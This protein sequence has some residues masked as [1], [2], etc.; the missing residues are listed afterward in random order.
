MEV[1]STIITSNMTTEDLQSTEVSE[2]PLNCMERLL[3]AT[4]L[5]SSKG[6]IQDVIETNEF[7]KTLVLTEEEK[8]AV[9]FAV[10]T[11]KV[12][13]VDMH[14]PT[15]SKSKDFTKNFGISQKHRDYFK[16]AIDE[17]SLKGSLSVQ[18]DIGMIDLYNKL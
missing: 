9:D 11:K 15:Y 14:V 1:L 13:G 8:N 2:I 5:S 3:L 10:I 7:I 18:H 4:I 17:K 16:K 6:N 12:N